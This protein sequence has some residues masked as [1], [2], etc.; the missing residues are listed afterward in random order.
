[1]LAG[2]GIVR[3]VAKAIRENGW[4]P[5]VLDPVMVSTTGHRL[6]TTEAEDVIRE[7]CCASPPWSPQLDEAAS[8]PPLVRRGDDGMRAGETLLRFG[9]GPRW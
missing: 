7:S 5:L 2:A 6:L 3:L 1:M 4:Q 8:S 9:R